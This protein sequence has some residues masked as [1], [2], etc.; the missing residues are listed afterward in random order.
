MVDPGWGAMIGLSR[1]LPGQVAIPTRA[2]QPNPPPLRHPMQLIPG[3][4]PSF[5]S[6]SIPLNLEGKLQVGHDVPRSVVPAN[7]SPRRMKNVLRKSWLPLL[8]VMRRLRSAQQVLT[9]EQGDCVTAATMVFGGRE[10]RCFASLHNDPLVVEMKVANAVIRRILIYTGSSVDIITWDCLKKLTY[11]GRDIVPLVLAILGF[12]GQK[13]NPT[14]LIRL[15]LYFGDKLKARNLEVD[16]L[17]VEVPTAYNVILGRPTLH[18]VKKLK[19]RHT[20]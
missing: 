12:G 13:V 2:S 1:P 8:G 4:R 3:E 10:A 9:A 5:R 16:F 6:R 18:R 11:P 7:E 14:G 15:P 19:I 17:V 20:N